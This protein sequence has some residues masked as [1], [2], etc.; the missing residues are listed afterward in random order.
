[1][2]VLTSNRW[3]ALELGRH[4]RAAGVPFALYKQDGLF[5]TPEACEVADLLEA[6]AD[7]HDP[8]RR[9]RVWEGSYFGLGLAEV[10]RCHDLPGEHP[11]LRRLLDW[12]RHAERHGPASVFEQ[13]LVDRGVLRRE[14]VLVEH[15]RTL[16]NVL[17]LF[18]LL[19]ERAART[20]ATLGDLATFLRGRAATV[21]EPGEEDEDVQRLETESQAVQLLT[22]HKSKGLEAEVVVLFGGLTDP[23]AREVTPY[24][25][26]Q[27]EEDVDAPEAPKLTVYHDAQHRRVV[28][29]GPIEAGSEVARLVAAERAEEWSRVAYVAATRARARLYVTS[30][31]KHA[32]VDAKTGV[33]RLDAAGQPILEWDFPDL[34]GAHGALGER[35]HAIATGADP[36]AHFEVE[37]LE[38]E[39]AAQPDVDVVRAACEAWRPP[40]NLGLAPD[41]DPAAYAALRTVHA[42]RLLTSYSRMARD[43]GPKVATPAAT[44][45]ADAC[46]LYTSPSPRD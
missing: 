3:E 12:S 19:A 40:A 22:M 1:M 37:P 25:E 20:G 28:H 41:P 15:E 42:G 17:H 45:V 33:P 6:I 4:L 36:S 7:P 44:E 35:L 23:K 11:L 16:T 30:F 24:H 10:E 32:A 9:R 31:G 43:A 27:N 5:Q 38:F 34:G 26:P 39:V 18:D 21:G 2:F 14:L 46:L 29:V 13:V 8:S